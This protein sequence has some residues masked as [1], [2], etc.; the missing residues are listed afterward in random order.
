MSKLKLGLY[1]VF[2]LFLA[3]NIQITSVEAQAEFNET[4]EFYEAGIFSNPFDPRVSCNDEDQCV[5]VFMDAQ[6]GQQG[7]KVYYYPNGIPSSPAVDGLYK[8]II[9]NT[10][11]STYIGNMRRGLFMD[12]HLAYDV[13]F[14]D[15]NWYIMVQENKKASLYRW[16]STMGNSIINIHPDLGAG[17]CWGIV[18]SSSPVGFYNNGIEEIAVVLIVGYDSGSL[19]YKTCINELDMAGNIL[20]SDPIRNTY[21]GSGWIQGTTILWSSG[22]LASDQLKYN[23]KAT[24]SNSPTNHVLLTNF[25]YPCSINAL[26]FDIDN[27][28]YGRDY[29]TNTI[30]YTETSD[31]TSFGVCTHYATLNPADILNMSDVT[32]GKKRYWTSKSRPGLTG[33]GLYSYNISTN[34]INIISFVEDFSTPEP[35]EINGVDV[36]S[37]AECI[38][39]SASDGESGSITTL[40]LPCDDIKLN[41]DT[42][43]AF[44]VHYE[45]EFIYPS[46]CDVLRVNNNYY[47]SYDLQIKVIDSITKLPIHN[48]IVDLRSSSLQTDTT[49][50]NGEAVININPIVSSTFTNIT[51][52]DDCRIDNYVTGL[53]RNYDLQVTANNY[54]TYNEFTKNYVKSTFVGNGIETFTFESRDTISLQPDA[55]RII[56][57]TLRSDGQ[58]VEPVSAIITMQSNASRHLVK[59]PSDNQFFEVSSNRSQGIPSDWLVFNDDNEI[60]INVTIDYGTN[61]ETKEIELVK[62][63]NDTI[64]LYFTVDFYCQNEF[65]CPNSYCD[66][67]IF[68]SLNGCFQNICEY[69]TKNC[70]NCDD[71]IGCYVQGTDIYCNNDFECV[72]LSYCSSDWVSMTGLCGSDNLCKYQSISCTDQWAV[73]QTGC[74]NDTGLCTQSELCFADNAGFARIPFII[75]TGFATIGL[76]LPSNF[77][78]IE[79]YFAVAEQYDTKF[80][81]IFVCGLEDINKRTCMIPPDTPIMEN[82]S[83]LIY[84]VSPTNWKRTIDSINGVYK[85]KALSVTCGA[86]CNVSV[87][88][89]EDGCNALTGYCNEKIVETIED[90]NPL[91][92][93]NI[94]DS[95]FFFAKNENEIAFLWLLISLFAGAMTLALSSAKDISHGSVFGVITILVFIVMGLL[96][97]ALPLWV[98]IILAILTA[99]SV[100]YLFKG[101]LIGG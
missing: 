67:N 48:A 52:F 33:D 35:R 37:F 7:V 21:V 60:Y 50:Q 15:N 47:S 78:N 18:E 83:S 11:Q 38:S 100:V 86:G 41:L 91:A 27:K 42:G 13:T 76:Q 98:F 73:N 22:F 28:I 65:D 39:T 10:Y 31:Y 99:L 51:N 26:F 3:S 54:K 69:N 1:V 61:Q 77:F 2:I 80:S 97:G 93:G 89:C 29:S 34:Q 96:I 72:D 30:I 6:F 49:N 79:D 36:Y 4:S 82:G 95:I 71:R 16:N 63:V 87:E 9:P 43:D 68:T 94:L 32:Q 24:G 85:W 12:Y 75:S 40:N 45:T 8:I 23:I 101:S 74:N 58:E 59:R 57:R 19:S 56:V 14:Q 5:M 53:K 70:I 90:D 25:V 55:Y 46:A 66:G 62:G 44:P 17:T 88:T 81:A 20:S 84:A 64:N 92:V